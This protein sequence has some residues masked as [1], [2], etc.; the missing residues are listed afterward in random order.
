MKKI[1]VVNKLH[2][3]NLGILLLF[4]CLYFLILLPLTLFTYLVSTI[5]S[6]TIIY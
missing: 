2:L 1:Q 4:N 5:F 6:D 3:V